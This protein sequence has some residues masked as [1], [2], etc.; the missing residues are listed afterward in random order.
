MSPALFHPPRHP[1]T[2]LQAALTAG[3]PISIRY[4]RGV[5]QPWGQ[6]CKKKKGQVL[7]VYFMH[8]QSKLN[9]TC[10]NVS[11]VFQGV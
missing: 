7:V 1:R 4:T 9:P 3:P 8:L 11:A 10:R 6:E 5:A 2:H